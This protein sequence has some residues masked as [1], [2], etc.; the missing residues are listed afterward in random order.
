MRSDRGAVTAEL[1][2]VLP[3]VIAILGLALGG[4]GIQVD[5]LR[6]VEQASEAARAAARH[7]PVSNVQVFAQGELTCVRL[8]APTAFGFALT[9][10]ECVRTEGQ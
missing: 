9:D 3:T 8:R 4:L 2:V 7:E 10:T 5:H 6:L 1:V